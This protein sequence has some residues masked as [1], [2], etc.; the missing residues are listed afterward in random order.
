M[1]QVFSL[2]HKDP[3]MRQFTYEDMIN[4]YAAIGEHTG[5]AHAGGYTVLRIRED[6]AAITGTAHSAV[7]DSAAKMYSLGLIDADEGV[8]DVTEKL[9]CGQGISLAYRLVSAMMPIN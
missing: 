5:Y 7:R 2:R 1:P 3:K 6:E 4:G 8:V 9:S